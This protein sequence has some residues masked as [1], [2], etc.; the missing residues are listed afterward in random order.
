[1][2][3]P[4]SIL[5]FALLLLISC[6]YSPSGTNF[7]VSPTEIQEL[8]LD[9]TISPS[10]VINNIAKT[11][12]G[13]SISFNLITGNKSLINSHIW[14]DDD[15]TNSIW[16]KNGWFNFEESAYLN[17]HYFQDGLHYLNIE[18]V[19]STG[20]QNV[21]DKLGGEILTTRY[22]FPF[23][24]DNSA[25]EG[26][27]ITNVQHTKDKLLL[28]YEQSESF[29]FEYYYVFKKWP[30]ST[31]IYTVNRNP[32]VNRNQTTI[33]DSS[34][35][36]GRVEYTVRVYGNN[37]SGAG[38]PFVYEDTYP[39]I[40]HAD[41]LNKVATLTWTK[42]KYPNNFGFYRV[43]SDWNKEFYIYS[44]ND[45][46]FSFSYENLPS[47]THLELVTSSTLNGYYDGGSITRDIYNF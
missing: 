37:D 39:Q 40:I 41:T 12:G 30:N 47:L 44:I 17:T 15:S 24:I 8:D 3:E 16:G 31:Q 9:V 1:M 23:F 20:R 32:I 35:V 26:V 21:L 36:G 38:E 46:S 27:N 43:R 29:N 25:P 19:S 2:N 6:Q 34:Y 18:I 22:T 4:K 11:G 45:T 13:V 10:I 42:C 33:I 5:I 7:V 28:S 14:V